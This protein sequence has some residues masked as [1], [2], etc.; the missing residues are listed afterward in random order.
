MDYHL[1]S[2]DI[3][4]DPALDQILPKWQKFNGTQLARLSAPNGKVSIY[5]GSTWLKLSND[6]KVY[7]VFT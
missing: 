7:R 2:N 5:L 4:L 1:I 3:L 6:K